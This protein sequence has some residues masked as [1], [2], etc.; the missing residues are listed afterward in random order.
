MFFHIVSDYFGME[1]YFTKMYSDPMIVE[2]VTEHVVDFYLQIN[3]RWFDIAGDQIDAVFFGNDFGCQQDL[4]VSPELLDRFIFPHYSRIIQRAKRRGYKVVTHSC[5]AIDK[6]IPRLIDM[7]VDALHPI[8]AR[9]RGMD[10]C[11]LASKYKDKLIFIGGVDAQHLLPFGTTKQVYDEVC[12]LKDIFGSNYIVSPSH[13][14]LLSNIP[15]ENI[16]AMA[17]AALK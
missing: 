15:P 3:E 17:N 8:Q 5:G 16:E 2:A 7:G 13:E 12:R 10:A 4:M 11:T 9:A 14:S 1:N 6:I